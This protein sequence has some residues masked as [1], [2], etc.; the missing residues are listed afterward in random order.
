MDLCMCAS[1]RTRQGGCLSGK[2]LE[3]FLIFRGT[4]GAAFHLALVPELIQ[5]Q[6]PESWGEM[7]SS[8]SSLRGRTL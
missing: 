6:P 4:P 3:R 2:R 5:R 1:V 8:S 7:Q